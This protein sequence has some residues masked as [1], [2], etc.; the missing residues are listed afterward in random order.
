MCNC[1]YTINMNSITY[2]AQ[3]AFRLPKIIIKSLAAGLGY[4]HIS[5]HITLVHMQWS[6]IAW[7]YVCLYICVITR[8]LI[9]R[10]SKRREYII[11][12]ILYHSIGHSF[13]VSC[14]AF[15][16][17]SRRANSS[18]HKPT[19]QQAHVC[20]FVRSLGATLE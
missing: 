14:T 2:R 7:A 17:S 11:H 13:W 19:S 16:R 15:Y 9:R 5:G 3:T 18:Q 4:V 12:C 1:E 20:P 8:I 10:S 6:S